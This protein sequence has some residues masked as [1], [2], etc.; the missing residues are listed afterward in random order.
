MIN[1]WKNVIFLYQHNIKVKQHGKNY[2]RIFQAVEVKV[3][4]ERPFTRFAISNEK[5]ASR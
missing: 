3:V 4:Y 2:E 5:N 1:K